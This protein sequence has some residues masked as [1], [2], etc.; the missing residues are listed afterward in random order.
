[1]HR[2]YDTLAERL[3]ANTLIST[4]SFYESTPCWDWIGAFTVN[5]GGQ[6]YGKLSVRIK[7][8][9]RK[10]RNKTWKAHRLA[11]I[12][13]GARRLWPRQ[14]VQHLCNN[15]LCINP[16]HLLGG[17]Q[18]RNIRQCVAEGRHF[19]PFRKAA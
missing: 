14:V 17:S 2:K 7:R 10:G 12:E 4:V 6:R 1:M 11:V 13:L 19:T 16:A 5:R 3:M 8:G 18:K 15:S 9:V